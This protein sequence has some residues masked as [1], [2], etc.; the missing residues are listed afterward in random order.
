MQQAGVSLVVP[1]HNIGGSGS[2][3]AIMP[4]ISLPSVGAPL[5]GARRL[6]Y[7]R[8]GPLDS[9]AGSFEPHGTA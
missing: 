4:R 1:I 9:Q 6:T 8:Q 5:A 7:T 3:A 2:L